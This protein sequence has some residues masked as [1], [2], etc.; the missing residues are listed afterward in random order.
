MDDFLTQ[1]WF[2]AV[3]C[4][5]LVVMILTFFAVVFVK[6][7]HMKQSPLG[8][9]RGKFTCYYLVNAKQVFTLHFKGDISLENILG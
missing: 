7:K 9:I 3:L 8:S 5:C 2:I 6:G 1:P 4:T